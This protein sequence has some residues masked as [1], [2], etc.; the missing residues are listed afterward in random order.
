[1]H[2]SDGKFLTPSVSVSDAKGKPGATLFG[3]VINFLAG[4]GC[5]IKR[6]VSFQ[7][8]LALIK[9][10]GNRTPIAHGSPAW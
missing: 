9:S 1:M 2:G 8:F 4:P 5:M 10:T 7:M 6:R 3:S